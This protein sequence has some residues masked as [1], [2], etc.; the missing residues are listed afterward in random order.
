MD[1]HPA[2][3]HDEFDQFPDDLRSA[4]DLLREIEEHR[5]SDKKIIADWLAEQDESEQKPSFFERFSRF[6]RRQI[7][8][9]G[10]FFIFVLIV[11]INPI[12][13]TVT[14]SAVYICYRIFRYVTKKGPE[15]PQWLDSLLAFTLVTVGFGM[16]ILSVGYGIGS[17]IAG[18]LITGIFFTIC[19]PFLISVG[20]FFASDFFD[21]N[22]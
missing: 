4:D 18:E 22:L 11:I 7:V 16:L 12:V 6:F 21:K 15:P 14:F 10:L 8:E 17:L 3:S 2:I 20:G 19:F 9:F 5:E 1:K 13:I